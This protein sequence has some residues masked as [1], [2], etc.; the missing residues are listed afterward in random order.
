MVQE[1]G[2][3]EYMRKHYNG[4]SKNELTKLSRGWA[5]LEKKHHLACFDAS[6]S[7]WTLEDTTEALH[8]C[9]TQMGV[10]DPGS[11]SDHEIFDLITG[12]VYTKRMSPG[13]QVDY[14]ME[15]SW[16]GIELLRR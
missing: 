16:Q 15:G 7:H 9:L 14:L 12:K 8:A 10:D 4:A 6:Q 3:R 5:L 2:Y 1:L 11:L 13:E